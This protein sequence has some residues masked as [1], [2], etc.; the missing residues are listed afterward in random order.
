MVHAN[1]GVVLERTSAKCMKACDS[2]GRAVKMR[3]ADG[4]SEHLW[5]VLCLLLACR[6]KGPEGPGGE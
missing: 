2:E 3:I 6:I 1:V 4:R 5:L